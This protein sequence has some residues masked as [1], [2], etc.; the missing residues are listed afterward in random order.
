M[1][2]SHIYFQEAPPCCHRLDKRNDNRHAEQLNKR[3]N[4]YNECKV[5][6]LTLLAAV[7]NLKCFFYLI[8]VFSP[9]NKSFGIIMIV[10]KQQL[11]KLFLG[12]YNEY[13]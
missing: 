4:K 7:K 3:I 6:E 11:V 13:S 9:L 5:D 8:H 12:C 10:R 2:T 1:P